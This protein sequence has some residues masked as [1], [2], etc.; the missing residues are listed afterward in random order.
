MT[1][2]NQKLILDVISYTILLLGAVL[3][4]GPFLWMVSTSFKLPADQFSKTLI[5]PHFTLQNFKELFA[6]DLNFV[7]L[8]FNSAYISI[9]ITVGQLLSCAMAAFCFAVVKFR[10]RNLLFTALLLTLLIPPQVTLIPNFII[11][12]YLH[13]IGSSVPLWLP[14]FLGGAFGTFLLRQYFLTIPNDLV[15]AAR[16]DGASLL[17]IFW[18]IYMPL[19]KPALAALAIFTFQGAWNDLLHPLVYMPSVPNTMLTVGLAFFQTQMTHG[20]KFTVL[21]AGALISILPLVIVFFFAQRLFIQG[22]AL[23]GVKR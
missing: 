19:A 1:K 20:G 5:P 4:V 9:L 17:Q 6:V 2:Q 15:D 13:L 10:G 23:S 3:M 7:L 22:I 11:F 12:K 21:M 8:F 18:N 16:V 14:A